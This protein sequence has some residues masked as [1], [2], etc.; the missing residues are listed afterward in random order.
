MGLILNVEKVGETWMI[1]TDIQW[2]I[3]YQVES[4]NDNNILLSPRECP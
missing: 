1:L 2:P 4:N 3:K